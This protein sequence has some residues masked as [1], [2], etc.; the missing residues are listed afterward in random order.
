MKKTLVI[1][2][3][4]VVSSLVLGCSTVPVLYANNQNVEYEILGR[5][6][7][8]ARQ[9]LYGSAH[10]GFDDL[11]K[12]AKRQYPN[13]DFIIDVTVDRRTLATIGMVAYIMQGTAVR[14]K[15]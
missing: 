3:V 7:Y 15:K 4:C 12:E 2:F 8:E 5:V 1:V 9:G 6:R 11:L 13:C 10:A 14:Y